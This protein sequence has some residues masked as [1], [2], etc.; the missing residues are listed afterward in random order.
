MTSPRNPKVHELYI[1]KVEA[2][3]A[4]ITRDEALAA[5]VEPDADP[6]LVLAFL[7]Y[8]SA[9][10]VDMTR[11]VEDWI[12]RAGQRCQE[13]GHTQLGRALVMHARHEAGHHTMMIDDLRKLVPRW[14][15]R[16]EPKLDVDRLL[17][18]QPT[19]A[20]KRYIA[21]HEDTIESETPYGQIAIEYE[22]EGMSVVLGPALMKACGQALGEEIIQEMSFIHEHAAL[23]VGHTAMN[24][25]ELEKFLAINPS[26]AELLAKIGGEALHI[27]LDFLG[28]CV[29]LG[30]EL[31]ATGEGQAAVSA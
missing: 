8:F 20:M 15:Q 16:Y 6:Q 14:N 13:L 30:R 18:L 22:V 27:Y 7:I 12:L 4:R 3:R 23:D 28:E 17:A 31:V 26:D 9:L 10:G 24:E 5:I 11:Q 29:R 19:D 21:I 25:A 1:P 2:A